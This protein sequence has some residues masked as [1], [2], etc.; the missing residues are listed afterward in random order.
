MAN[1]DKPAGFRVAMMPGEFPVLTAKLTANVSVSPG[2][3]LIMQSTGL[4]DIALA[5]SATIWGVCQ[6]K[7]T[8]AAGVTPDCLYVPALPTI[9]FSG[10][11][12]GTY[13]L[14][15]NGTSVDIEGTTGIME[16]NENAVA[17]AVARVIGLEPG[18]MNAVGL[19]SRVQFIWT[20]SQFTGQ[21]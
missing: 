17:T 6:S 4:L 21:A 18:L 3:A 7:I 12:S 19:N 10:Q 1:V 20:K 13:A 14:T 2:D 8:G 16:I 9:V 5:A 15:I 11:C